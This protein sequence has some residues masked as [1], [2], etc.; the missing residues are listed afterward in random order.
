MDIK[1]RKTGKSWVNFPT[2]LAACLID[3]F[4]DTF[5]QIPERNYGRPVVSLNSIHPTTT[6]FSVVMLPN[7]SGRFCIKRVTPGGA[8]AFDSPDP[9]R[10]KLRDAGFPPA[11]VDEYC[12]CAGPRIDPDVAREIRLK[13]QAEMEALRKR[14]NSFG[15][16]A[17]AGERN[18]VTYK[19]SDPAVDRD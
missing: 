17:Q 2:G 15:D 12:Q 8:V 4:P 11:V 13:Q 3:A 16:I 18:T 14:Q 10:Q 7:G 9:D 6:Q 1:N 19:T 5:E